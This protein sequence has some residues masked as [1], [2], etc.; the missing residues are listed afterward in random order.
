MKNYTRFI[1]SLIGIC[2]LAFSFSSCEKENITASADAPNLRTL[3]EIVEVVDV[4]KS[5]FY[6]YS[7]TGE[8]IMNILE[9]R[10]KNHQRTIGS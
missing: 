10:P 5:D 9:D 6:E 8:E 1:A 4:D 2:L 3:D 7:V